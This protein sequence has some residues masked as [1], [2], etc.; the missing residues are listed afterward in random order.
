MTALHAH[1]QSLNDALP[2]FQRAQFAFTAH[3]RDPQ[4]FAKPN[5]VE[6]RRMAIYR[7]LLINNVSNFLETGFP[8]LRSLLD[9]NTWQALARDFFANHVSH[10][11]Y[12]TDISS[13]FVQY[14][15]SEKSATLAP[16]WPFL[17]ELAHY[18]W[19]ELVALIADAEFP[20]EVTGEIDWQQALQ[21]SPLAWPL[22]YQFPVHKIGPSFMPDEPEPTQLLVYRDN[23]D[24]VEF[25]TLTGLSYL[26]LQALSEQA[27]TLAQ[28]AAI[29]QPQLPGKSPAQLEHAMRPMLTEFIQRCLII[30]V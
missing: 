15:A 11:P 24:K 12:F 29:L 3:I 1:T 8:V 23:D 19:M 13:E 30:P 16:S 14:L 26:L 21:L 17:V 18:E 20:S 6:D 22:A 7:E 4:S 2:H 25:M 9:D 27:L 10:S 28:I 5:D